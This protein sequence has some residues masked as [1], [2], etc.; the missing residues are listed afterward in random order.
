[1]LPL[2]L[3]GSIPS[4]ICALI[5]SRKSDGSRGPLA[6][7]QGFVERCRGRSGG[8]NARRERQEESAVGKVGNGDENR[9]GATRRV[10]Q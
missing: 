5:F 9:H 2:S 8:E 4:F 7:A 1:M 3:S 6:A 10:R